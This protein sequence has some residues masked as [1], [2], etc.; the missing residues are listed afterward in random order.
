MVD[1]LRES[2][3]VLHVDG[4]LIDLRPLSTR[5]PIEAVAG[6][7][8]FSLGEGDGTA[9][10]DDDRAADRAIHE[11]VR[12]GL[13]TPRRH[14]AFDIHFYWDTTAEMADFLRSGRVP[15]RVTP[16]Y[17]DIDAG[18]RAASDRA[19]VHTRLRAT[20]RMI[21]GSYAARL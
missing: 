20:R 18:L 1:A 10:A 12:T 14:F 13:L 8:A 21:I 16:A 19:G 5:F 6:A 3:R 11:Q 9:T 15:K 7:D 4:I 17:A 2:Y